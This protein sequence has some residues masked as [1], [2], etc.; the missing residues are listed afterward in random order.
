MDKGKTH[1]PGSKEETNAK[2]IRGPFWRF[3]GGKWRAAPHYPKPEYATIIEPFAGSAG[4]SLRYADRKVILIERDP[5]I[6]ELWRYLISVTGEELRRIP[7]V[8]S[9]DELPSWVPEGGRS[10][11]GFVMN[12]ACAR[13]RERLS[14]GR[15][16]LRSM[17][18]HFEGWTPARAERTAQAVEGIRHW[19]V[20]EGSYHIAP[21]VEATWFVDP[22]YSG[23][24]GRHYVFDAIDYSDLA[25]WSKSRKG[26]VMVCENVG[27]DW[28]PFVP[29]KDLK[30]GIGK[31]G[32]KEKSREAL[33]ENRKGRFA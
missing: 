5:V 4:Y 19:K 31:F 12:D 32:T 20:L 14:A 10:L 18:R 17:G 29:F 23:P 2:N 28:L 11:V 7:D 26:Q 33:W 21:D 25:H 22:P 27:A 3:Y 8:M 30:G 9:V 1:P 16:K 6:A 24:A 15:L 13:P